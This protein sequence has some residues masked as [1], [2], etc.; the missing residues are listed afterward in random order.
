MSDSIA[1]TEK[2]YDEYVKYYNKSGGSIGDHI[3]IFAEFSRIEETV[4]NRRNELNDAIQW[5]IESL[6]EAIK[7]ISDKDFTVKH[8]KNA[9]ELMQVRK[10][11]LGDLKF[12]RENSHDI[13]LKE[14]IDLLKENVIKL[15]EGLEN[16]GQKFKLFSFM[17]GAE[18]VFPIYL[19]SNNHRMALKF[20][21]EK[22]IDEYYPSKLKFYR[23]LDD[24]EKRDLEAT[25]NRGGRNLVNEVPQKK[26]QAIVHECTINKTNKRYFHQM[27]KNKGAP[28]INQ[29]ALHVAETY[30]IMVNGYGDS[31]DQGVDIKTIK[32]RVKRALKNDET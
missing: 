29:I 20:L 8:K 21:N 4:K 13:Y 2:V 16:E 12:Y 26:I 7:D 30:P 31:P 18:G 9:M 3:P 22:I 1:K 6:F 11:A 27:G 28:N 10:E 19:Q 25:K 15:A 5:F 23:K 17:A 14:T 32:R 24:Q